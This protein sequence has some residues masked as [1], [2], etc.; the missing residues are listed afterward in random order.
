MEGCGARS[1]N[2]RAQSDEKKSTKAANQPKRVS[3]RERETLIEWLAGWLVGSQF[4]GA[5]ETS[6]EG[7]EAITEAAVEDTG[8]MSVARLQIVRLQIVKTHL[9]A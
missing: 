2:Q 3:E 8:S 5:I 1:V 4:D 7:V 9:L 6:R